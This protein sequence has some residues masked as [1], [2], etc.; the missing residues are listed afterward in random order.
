MDKIKGTIAKYSMLHDG[1]TVVVGLSG[2]ADSV[3]LLHCLKALDM[4]LNLYAVYIDHGLRPT[5]TPHEIEFCANLCKGLGVSFCEE[6]ISLPPK[7]IANTQDTLR[8]LRYEILEKIAYER[9]AARIAIG[10][11]KDDQAE[12]VLLHFIR[13]SS[14]AGLG[15]IPPVRGKIIRPLIETSRVDIENFLESL[16]VKFITDSS[17]LTQKYMRN[18]VRLSLLPMLKTYNPNIVDTLA[19]NADIIRGEDSYIERIAIKKTM[20]L[21]SRRTDRRLELF[22]SPLQTIEKTILRRVLKTALGSVE[23]MKGIGAVHIDDIITLVNNASAG[24]SIDLP[25]GIRAIKGYSILTITTEEKPARINTYA[26]SV[27][28]ELVIKEAKVVLRAA[29]TDETQGG[30]NKLCIIVDADRLKY[31]L[32]VRGRLD[33]DYFYPV[34]FGK[35]KKVQDFF[36]DDKVPKDARDSIP[37]VLS[38]GD[39]VWIAGMRGDE[40]FKPKIDTQ[41]CVKLELFQMK[42]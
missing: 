3:T 14:L 16:G 39:I 5:E 7:I 29:L 4:D 12:T 25:N 21:I 35:R 28:G 24:A 41:R 42:T 8:E 9:K 22:L 11:N 38:G 23:T 19:R 26:L 15:G 40:R 37:L 1:D 13:G 32:T 2:G 20:T 31:P 10:H 30:E 18:K 17:N 27:P 34:G 36:V 6:Q 33:G